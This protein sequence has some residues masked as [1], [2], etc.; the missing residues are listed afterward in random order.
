[1]STRAADLLEPIRRIHEGIR[2]AV[3]SAC[4]NTSSEELAGIVH[5]AE[6]DTIYAIDR[7]SEAVLIEQFENDIARCT[8]IVLI[9]EGL[10]GGKLVLPR[11]TAEPDALFRIIIDP[12]DGTRGIMYQKRSAWVL[13]GVA[14]N[15]GPQTSLRDIELA[16]QTE[17]PLLKQY[18]CDVL[19]AARGGGAH[20]ERFNR[21]TGRRQSLDLQP[22]RAGTIA[23][24]YA[25]LARFF[26]GARDILAAVD[27][28]MVRRTIGPS[29]PGKANCF[30]D[31]YASTGGQLYELMVGHDR[32]VGDLRP[33]LRKVLA[34]RGEPLGLCCHPYDICTAL[35]AGESGVIVTDPCGGPLDALLDVAADVAW[36]GYA[37]EKIR[38]QVEPALMA[39]LQAHGLAPWDR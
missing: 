19:W 34:A 11:G 13:T 37:N 18:L 17:I 1:V 9:A 38:K 16:V 30:E 6:G 8:P 24:G 36:L 4:E 25:M 12:I 14:P 26:P 27:E 5:D 31:Q 32:F 7:I 39:A 10:N 23:Q 21:L 22:S 28:E 15:C 33:L 35:I 20:A 2:D 3:I 29:E